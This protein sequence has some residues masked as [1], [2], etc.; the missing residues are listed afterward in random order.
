MALLGVCIDHES[1]AYHEAFLA[2]APRVFAGVDF[3]PWYAAYG[4][5]ANYRAFA[6]LESG[7]IVANVSVSSMTL[8]R[9]GRAVSAAQLGAV[10]TAAPYRG[11]GLSRR[12]L[13]RALDFC[14]TSANQVFLFANDSV[15]DFYP[16]WGFQLAPPE[17]LFRATVSLPLGVPARRL[18]LSLDRDRAL[19]LEHCASAAP[20]SELFGAVDYGSILFFHVTNWFEHDVFHLPEHDALVVAKQEADVLTIFDIV[21]E[22]RFDLAEA[23][24]HLVTAPVRQVEFGFTPDVYWP[25][26]TA[27]RRYEESPLFV[28]DSSFLPHA[29]FKFPLLAQT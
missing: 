10:G 19:L 8:I 25:S 17:Q 7:A 23:L 12:L 6:L 18:S 22:H 24:P 28:R 21:C 5:P 20:V 4:W 14:A 2:F 29:P 1:T 13:E 11:R 15:L 16:R 26:A 27:N 9:A 3:R